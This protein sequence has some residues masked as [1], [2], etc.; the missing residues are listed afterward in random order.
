MALSDT[1]AQNYEL[2]DPDVRLML[3]V[4]D[5]NAAAFEE[6]VLRYQGRLITV[7]EQLVHRR[8]VAEDLAQE[9]FLRVF[10]A[11]KT[12]EPGAKFSTWLFTIANNVASNALRSLARRR[13]VSLAPRRADDSHAMP[14]EQLALAASG[15]M[16]ARQLDKQERAEI[17]RQ[18]IQGLS[19][20][21]KM[22]LLLSKFEGMSYSDIGQAM[23]LTTQAVKS[24]LSRA[25]GNLRAALAPYIKEGLP[26]EHRSDE[27]S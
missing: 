27:S 13:E 15:L 9:V 5:D 24:L 12:Y 19:Q 18:A 14:L 21:Q 7:L 2:R 16:P 11:R 25:R 22:A 20:R 1:T 10:R 26:P 6:L 8:D 23:D 3:Q 17:V 4:R